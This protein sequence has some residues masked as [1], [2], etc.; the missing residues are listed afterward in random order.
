[1]PIE[2]SFCVVNTEQREL[3][4]RCL[5]AIAAEAERL[6]FTTEVLVLDNASNDGSVGA[7]RAHP[8]VT[9]VLALR[10]RRGKAENDS[11][12]LQ[13]AR[14]RYALLLN[15]DSELCEGAV[16]ALHAAMAGNDRAAAAGARLL[17]PDGTPQPSAW[18]FPGLR[19]ALIG[20][21]FLHRR[22]TVQ[23]RG[24]R[25][26]QVDWAQSAALLVRVEA[27]RAIGYFDP[28]FF[29]YSD[30]VDF[31]KRL[32]NAGWVS[33][34]VPSAVAYHHEQLSTAAVP[35]RRIVELSRNRDRYMR[36]HHSPIDAAL[37][38]GLTAWAYAVRSLAALVIP[39]HDPRRYWR[40]VTATLRPH[41]GEGLREAAIEHN[42][43]RRL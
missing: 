4:V 5:D 32:R 42:K 6:P 29:V 12:L 35:E 3:L 1:M 30:E 25:T 23:S 31:C 16:A 22:L 19:T 27:A 11:A 26:R 9:E 21:L 10:H 15:E 20:A 24:Q 13:R 39:G 38:R 41:R 7:A 28:A 34:H 40:H 18:R 43:G 17:R 8:V 14:G 33:L 2:V 36:K 37:V